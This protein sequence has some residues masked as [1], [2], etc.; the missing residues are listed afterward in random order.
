MAI[1]KKNPA[2][3]IN[4][5]NG[6]VEQGHVDIP[7]KN[8]KSMDANIPVNAMVMGYVAKAFGYLP[9]AVCLHDSATW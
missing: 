2:N 3:L 5:N 1:V 6:D 4:L 9:E 8:K 7:T